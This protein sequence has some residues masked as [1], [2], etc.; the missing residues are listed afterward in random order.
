MDNQYKGMTVNERL[1]VSGLMEKFDLAV[2]EKNIEKVVDILKKVE[3]TDESSIKPI[4]KE[5]GL[6]EKG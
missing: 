1:Y 6:I 5:L 4:L 3:I 2:E